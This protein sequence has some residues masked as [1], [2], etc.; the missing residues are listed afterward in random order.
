MKF[1]LTW[2]NFIQPVLI[3][4]TVFEPIYTSVRNLVNDLFNT[5]Y[6]P[7][8]HSTVFNANES[9]HF[10]HNALL[11]FPLFLQHEHH[12]SAVCVYFCWQKKVTVASCFNVYTPNRYHFICIQFE[13]RAW[14]C[15]FFSP[16][17]C[18]RN[19]I[20]SFFAFVSPMAKLGESYCEN[21]EFGTGKDDFQAQ[22]ER[23]WTM[24]ENW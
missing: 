14:Q 11:V 2:L 13:Q 23:H 1:K 15:S 18:N 19:E 17:K 7:H 21:E 6:T 3:S 9:N 4:V 10:E 24:A 8:H 16:N 20:S 5:C 12:I 22:N